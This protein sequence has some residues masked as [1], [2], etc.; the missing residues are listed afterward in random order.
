MNRKVVGGSVGIVMIGGGLIVA[1][2][3]ISGYLASMLAALFAPSQLVRI[4]SKNVDAAPTFGVK[5]A[6]AGTP[7]TQLGNGGHVP[8]I[9]DLPGQGEIVPPEQLNPGTP[10]V[11]PGE[12]PSGIGELIPGLGE[13][14]G[15]PGF[16]EL[17]AAF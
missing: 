16:P 14:P 10:T 4:T 1:W 8:Q 3:G 6:D 12:L 9:E 15:I 11:T 17:P 5:P 7:P 13:L 2:G